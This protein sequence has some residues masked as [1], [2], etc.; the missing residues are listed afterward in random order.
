MGRGLEKLEK[1]AVKEN[2]Q[3]FLHY[4]QIC[5]QVSQSQDQNTKNRIHSNLMVI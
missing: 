4:H 5:V 1:V 2:S 3:T